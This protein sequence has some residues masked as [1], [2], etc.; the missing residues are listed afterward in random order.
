MLDLLDFT[1]II[2]MKTNKKEIFYISIKKITFYN[3]NCV[4][5]TQKSLFLKYTK[6]I[7]HPTIV[8]LS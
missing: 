7:Q 3:H 6:E 2:Q 5:T 4:Y 1:A 8:I